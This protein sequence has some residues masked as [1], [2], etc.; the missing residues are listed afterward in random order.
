MPTLFFNFSTFFFDILPGALL[1]FGVRVA[2]GLLNDFLTFILRFRNKTGVNLG[3]TC[4]SKNTW[5]DF[6]YR[7]T[8][9]ASNAATTSLPESLK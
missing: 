7:S 8:N 9:A 6:V 4:K 3:K 5:V 1:N 2:L